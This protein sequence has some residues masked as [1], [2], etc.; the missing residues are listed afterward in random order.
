MWIAALLS[1]VT[2][3]PVQSLADEQPLELSIDAVTLYRNSAMVHRQAKGVVGGSYVVAGLPGEVTDDRTRVRFVG[4]HVI[5]VE[6]AERV[7][8]HA[9]VERIRALETARQAARRDVRI[10]RDEVALSSG[11]VEYLTRLVVEEGEAWS[12][13]RGQ[14]RVD[15]E[16][17]RAN[18]VW[19]E[20]ALGQAREDRRGAQDRLREAERRFAEFDAEWTRLSG[21]GGVIVKDLHVR[22]VTDQA[23]GRLEVDT[24]LPSAGWEPLYDLRTAGDATSVDLAYRARIHQRTGE[25]WNDVRVLLSTAQP[26]LGAQGPDPIARWVDLYVPRPE[27]GLVAGSVDSMA[28]AEKAGYW[29][30]ATADAAPYAEAQQEGLSV[31]FELPSRETVESREGPTSVLVGRTQLSVTPEYYCAPAATQAVWLRGRATNGGDWTLL[32]GEASVFFGADYLGRANLGLVQPGQ[33]FMLH[34]GVA[35]A[36]EVQRRQ[37]N[38]KSEGPGFFGSQR[39][40]VE[41]WSIELKNHGA[42][43]ADADG[44]ASVIVQ[45]ALPR[46]G[47]DRIEVVVEDER[48]KRSLDER[49]RVEWDDRSIRTWIVRVPSGSSAKLEYRVSVRY[50]KNEQIYV[51]AR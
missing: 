7:L 41:E 38:D 39:A 15:T 34:L 32:P 37:V 13:E 1:A 35:D 17:W 22:V 18:R 21:A 27:R 4:G 44:S 50:P 23:S 24:Q 20:T 6:L 36:F 5:S 48:P 40:Q 11:S 42:L 47:D 46:P 49:W 51:D 2:F 19:F 33:E 30:D 28:P 14:G 12:R 16:R 45:E 25:D 8:E 10:A 26:E 31:R 43:I 29:D 9:P 3:F